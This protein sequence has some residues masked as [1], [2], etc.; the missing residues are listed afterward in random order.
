MI[1]A[2][3]SSHSHQGKTLSSKS[4]RGGFGTRCAVSAGSTLL[5]KT[6]SPLSETRRSTPL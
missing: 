6:E 3:M 2:A 1:A 5:M 4:A